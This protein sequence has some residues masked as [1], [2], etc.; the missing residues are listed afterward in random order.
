MKKETA[1]SVPRRQGILAEREGQN[2]VK[3]SLGQGPGS[4]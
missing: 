1:G 4:E 3:E 2:A